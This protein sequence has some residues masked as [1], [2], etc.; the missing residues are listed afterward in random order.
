MCK[1]IVCIAIALLSIHSVVSAAPFNQELEIRY[2]RVVDHPNDPYF[3]I[4]VKLGGDYNK[5]PGCN[6][7]S[8]GCYVGLAK[9]SPVFNE[10]YSL[11]LSAMHTGK[12]I[13]VVGDT[14]TKI[15]SGSNICKLSEAIVCQKTGCT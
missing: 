8:G 4:A 10:T 3:F 7:D 14:D 15:Y 6:C 9:A 1:K 11:A 12:L 5:L 2:I 13:R